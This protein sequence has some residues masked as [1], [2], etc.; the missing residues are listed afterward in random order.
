MQC[1]SFV[2]RRIDTHRSAVGAQQMTTNAKAQTC[3]LRLGGETAFK[4]SLRGRF[5]HART[6]VGQPHL[7]ALDPS[8]EFDFESG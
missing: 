3:P 7:D 4:R 2:V 5:V 8:T 1:R 6:I